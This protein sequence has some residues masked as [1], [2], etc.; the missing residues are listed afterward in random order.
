M[1]KNISRSIYFLMAVIFIS[2]ID[3]N[4]GCAKPANTPPAPSTERRSEGEAAAPVNAGSA[5]SPVESPATASAATIDPPEK[6]VKDF[7]TFYV[8]DKPEI[9][10]KNRAKFAQYVTKRFI[11]EAQAAE[12][13]DPFLDVQDWDESYNHNFKAT[14]ISSSDQKATVALLFNGKPGPWKLKI[15]LV[16]EDG[17]WK[18]DGVEDDNNQ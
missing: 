6:V 9:T 2:A 10:S 15:K 13:A 7:Y 1:S 5:A 4:T 11:K 16:K 14:V 3:L 18:I 12:D 8:V 17:S